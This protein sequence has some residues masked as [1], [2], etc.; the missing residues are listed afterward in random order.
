MSSLEIQKKAIDIMTL[1]SVAITN[2]R[3][4][5]PTSHIIRNTIN[6]LYQLFLDILKEEPSV[7]FAESGNN[8]IICGQFF[9]ENDQKKYPQGVNF[10]EMLTK[11]GIRS[12]A[13]ERKLGKPELK[14]F[15]EIIS[16]GAEE[17]ER[18]GGL[19]EV[20]RHEELPNIIVDHKVYV[21]VDKDQRIVAS[22][23]IGD[24]DIVK[25]VT[26]EH[27]LS[28]ADLKKI[29][30][31]ARDPK[32]VNQVFQAGMA[33][34]MGRKTQHSYEKLS[35]LVI[36]MIRTIDEI[37]DEDNREKIAAELA[38]SVSEME[39][40]MLLLLLGQDTEGMFSEK[41]LDEVL[42]L[43]DDKKFERIASKL[44]HKSAAVKTMVPDAPPAEDRDIALEAYDFM[45][46]TGK[47]KRLK[48]RIQQRIAMEKARHE[49]R[50]ARLKEGLTGILK[51]DDKGFHDDVVLEMLPE[52]IIGLISVKKEKT[53]EKVLQAFAKGLSHENAEVRER[54][55]ETVAHVGRRLL[56]EGRIDLMLSALSPA[57]VEWIRQEPRPV[58]P[59][60]KRLCAQMQELAQRL[61]STFRIEETNSIFQVFYEINYLKLE[62]EA[63]IRKI[64]TDTMRETATAPI[65]DILLD[66]FNANDPHRK[67]QAVVSLRLLGDPSIERILEILQNSR[68]MSERARILQ[69]IGEIGEHAADVLVR[70]IEAGGP[71]FYLRNLILMLGKVGREDDLRALIPLLK[72]EDLRVQ[73]ETL[74]AIYNIG[75][76]YRGRVLLSALPDADERLKLVIVDMLG[77]LKHEAAVSPLIDLLE[78]KTFFSTK[79]GEKLK[80]KTCAALGRIGSSRALPALK[81][82]VTQKSLLGIKSYPESLKAAAAKALKE[83][84][85][86]A[87]A[88]KPR[89]ISEGPYRLPKPAP[90]KVEQPE[91]HP[92]A[93]D[94]F[95]DSFRD[96]DTLEDSAVKMLYESIVKHAREKNFEQAEMLREQLIELDSMALNEIIRSGEIIE[97]EKNASG[98]VIQD[99]MGIW[100]ELYDNLT[101]DEADTLYDALEEA[102]FDTDQVIFRQGE[103]NHRLYF[104][105]RGQ[106]KLIFTQGERESLL[107]S[108]DKGDIIG[109][110]TFFSASVC[111]TT[112]VT[113]SRTSVIY[114]EKSVLD[115][116]RDAFPALETKLHDF[117]LQFERVQ[118]I[119]RQKGMDR[120]VQ[121]RVRIPGVV[122]IHLLTAGGM[123]T[124]KN[125]KGYLMD[126]S[127]GGLAFMIRSPSRRNVS[128]LLGR[129]LGLSFT[130]PAREGK[131][132]ELGALFRNGN[133]R[134]SVRHRGT[135]I[136]VSHRS[137]D[138]YS[139]HIKFELLLSEAVLKV[140][141][142]AAVAQS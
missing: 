112:L 85:A 50:M 45:M 75:G 25:F 57:I 5:P 29:R 68:D 79:I 60:F 130:I 72:H 117:C 9:S 91:T 76:D 43:L 28:E 71:W 26:G 13:F 88:P 73:R 93:D 44:K 108:L 135:V 80:E 129:K 84:E 95:D 17:V 23:D 90:E 99:H 122:G 103:A 142:S 77:A 55:A 10:L 58:K 6:R 81:S 67:K 59:V 62:R 116:W 8:Y 47:G 74:N 14:T 140:D 11:F 106:L 38:K 61:I 36:N 46:R 97:E 133:K 52:Y 141:A 53:A 82:I 134:L 128:L 104:V 39:D 54:A 12:I 109:E 100:P 69:L 107:K 124:G 65:L 87:A 31:M 118:D 21:V 121:K 137:Q 41:L 42:Q 56:T 78:L 96:Q 70:K 92:D 89:K 98:D 19:E 111:T 113:L 63:E 64:V 22:L 2:I 27:P 138:E 3:L 40:D 110:D 136:G 24:E 119:L 35:E 102:E 115:S 34:I 101:P 139:V 33:Y 83:I 48:N 126:L 20:M 86:S 49:K 114:L 51:G 1:M 125:F 66:E 4:Y 132:L 16:R 15:L 30:E 127:I 120:R 18:D 105:R 37:A 7:I 94:A 131:A 123:R 32:W